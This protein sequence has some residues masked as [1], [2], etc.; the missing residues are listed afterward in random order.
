MKGQI[1][2]TFCI[3]TGILFLLFT[4]YTFLLENGIGKEDTENL[5]VLLNEIVQLTAREDGS[6]P[7]KAQFEKLQEEVKRVSTKEQKKE[8]KKKGPPILFF[9]LSMRALCFYTFT[10]N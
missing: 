3:C 7:A 9:C 10:I 8:I 4:G 2:K 1:I 5:N 6:N